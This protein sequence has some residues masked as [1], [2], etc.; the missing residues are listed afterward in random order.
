MAD[1]EK[2]CQNLVCSKGFKLFQA[3]VYHVTSSCPKGKDFS[4]KSVKS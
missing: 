3:E 1:I 4:R 2:I